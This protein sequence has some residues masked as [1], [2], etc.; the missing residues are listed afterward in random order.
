M[1]SLQQI[2][3]RRKA[4]KNVGQITKA[5]EVVAYIIDQS[6][7]KEKALDGDGTP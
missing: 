1:A 7:K 5:M 3:S 2:Q 6:P 4:V